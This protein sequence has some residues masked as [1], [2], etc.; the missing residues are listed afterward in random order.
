M[1]VLIPLLLLLSLVHLVP[2]L[3]FLVH[4]LVQQW[5]HSHRLFQSLTVCKGDIHFLFLFPSPLQ[6]WLPSLLTPLSPPCHLEHL[7]KVSFHN[8]SCEVHPLCNHRLFWPMLVSIHW[9]CQHQMAGLWMSHYWVG[10][11]YDVVDMTKSCGF[12]SKMGNV[13]IHQ[14]DDWPMYSKPHNIGTK[15]IDEL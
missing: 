5:F 11:Q 12:H 14:Q 8:K 6:F 13:S 7:G 2:P 4:H 3:V 1:N 9:R 15:I 10:K